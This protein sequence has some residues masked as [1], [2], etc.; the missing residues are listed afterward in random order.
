[1]KM[2]SKSSDER[3]NGMA[4]EAPSKMLGFLKIQ[5]QRKRQGEGYTCQVERQWMCLHCLQD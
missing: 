3:L 1:M 5:V 4:V 2:Y